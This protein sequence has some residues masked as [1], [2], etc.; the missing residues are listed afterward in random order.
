[1]TNN[2]RLHAICYLECAYETNLYLNLNYWVMHP[3]A[4]VSIN[5]IY[6]NLRTQQMSVFV[7]LCTFYTTCFGP[8]SSTDICC[9]RRFL[10]ILT[11]FKCC[12][13]VRMGTEVSGERITSIFR[14]ENQWLGRILPSGSHTD[15]TALH[16]KRWQHS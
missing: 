7:L 12:R 9:V 3:V 13:V 14:V 2:I 5:I 11:V 1:M 4:R 6:R 10:Y 15:Y 16:P 8:Y